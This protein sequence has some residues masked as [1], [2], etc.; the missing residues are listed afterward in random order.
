[1]EPTENEHPIEEAPI[2]TAPQEEPARP[3]EQHVEQRQTR[4][5]RVMHNTAHY[6]EGLEQQGQGIVAWEVLI[7]Q[8]EM[9]DSPMAQRQYE[10]QKGMQ[11][12]VAY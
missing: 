10:I 11:E 12:P 2:A 8:D 5:G 7:S 6:S 3:S 4:S 9:E 1:M